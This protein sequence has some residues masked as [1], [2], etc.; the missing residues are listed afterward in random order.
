MGVIGGSVTFSI[1]EDPYSFFKRYCVA[2]SVP[3]NLDEE[4]FGFIDTQNMNGLKVFRPDGVEIAGVPGASIC[5]FRDEGYAITVL[6]IPYPF[7]GEEF[8]HHCDAYEKQFSCDD[9]Q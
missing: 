6:G 9:S 5:G 7:Y 8:P 2:H 4:E 1:A 3:I